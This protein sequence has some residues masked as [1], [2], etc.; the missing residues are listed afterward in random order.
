[1][2]TTLI[3]AMT[4]NGFVAGPDDDTNWITMFPDPGSSKIWKILLT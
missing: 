2:K 1:M 4:A 3:M